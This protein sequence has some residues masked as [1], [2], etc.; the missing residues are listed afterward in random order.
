MGVSYAKWIQ[1]AYQLEGFHRF[2]SGVADE[3]L[4]PLLLDIE[5]VGPGGHFLG[6]DHTRENAFL[7][8]RLQNNDSYE[9]WFEDGAKSGEK[10]GAEEAKRQLDHY[11][12][13]PISVDILGALDAFVEAKRKE[14]GR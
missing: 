7:M 9:Q 3:A 8:N 2:F 13:P 1:D 11:I 14:Y 10:V 12:E 4:D 6:T 5:N